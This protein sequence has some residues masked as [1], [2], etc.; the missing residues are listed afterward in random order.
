MQT[1]TLFHPSYTLA[2]VTLAQGESINAE[3]GA[4]VSMDPTISIETKARGGILKA[5]KR[6]FLG[7]ESFFINTF[8][9]ANGPGTI[10]LAPSLPGDMKIEQMKGETL[11]VQSGSYVASGEG[12]EIDTQWT[13]AKTFFASEGLFMLKASGTGTLILS[14]YGA[15]HEVELKAG[16]IWTVDTGHLVAFTANIGF[17]VKKVGGLK[18]TFFSGEG[19]VVDLQGPGKVLIQ[20]RSEDAFLA[21]LLPKI[22]KDRTTHSGG[23][24]RFN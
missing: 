20:T 13:G 10:T 3:G 1:E 17:N 11:L 7:G 21:W 4:M 23:G 22:P 5:L 2:Q 8:T 19:L 6:S 15:I 18:S 24:L 14:S 16:Q 12:V 9:A